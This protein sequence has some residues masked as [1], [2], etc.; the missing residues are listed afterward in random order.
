MRAL[1][2]LSG[3][4]FWSVVSVASA[5]VVDVAID[6]S[7][8]KMEVYVDGYRVHTWKISSARKG[9]STPKGDFR[10]QWVSRMH[11]SKKYDN[12]PMPYSVFFHFGY[13][14]HGTDVVSRLGRPAS[15]GCIRLHTNNARKLYNLVKRHG[16]ENIKIMVRHQIDSTIIASHFRGAFMLGGEEIN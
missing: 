2:I 3:L 5:D 16:K 6:I 11:Y 13:A 4:L 8:Q 10:P 1:Y 7:K 15:H 12:A 9:Y 14:I